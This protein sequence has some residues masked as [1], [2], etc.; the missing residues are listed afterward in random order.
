M[1]LPSSVEV[2]DVVDPPG[3]PQVGRFDFDEGEFWR[4]SIFSILKKDGM[5]RLSRSHPSKYRLEVP[6]GPAFVG[7]GAG[8]RRSTRWTSS[9]SFRF[10]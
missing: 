4:A 7:G 9:W 5:V 2:P 8:C 10:R 6:A 1:V 3:G